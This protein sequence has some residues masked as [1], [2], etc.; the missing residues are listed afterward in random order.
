MVVYNVG[1]KWW[2][3]YASMLIAMRTNI[4]YSFVVVLRLI[5]VSASIGLRFVYV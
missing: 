3:R 4:G 5:R 1:L 2:V